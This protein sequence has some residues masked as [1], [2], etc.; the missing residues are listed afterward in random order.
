MTG[1]A[2]PALCT[3]LAFNGAHAFLQKPFDPQTLS[4]ELRGIS[5]EQLAARRIED[6]VLESGSRTAYR[7]LRSRTRE[8][9][10]QWSNDNVSQAARILGVSRR[11]VYKLID[12]DEEAEGTDRT[13]PSD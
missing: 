8:R 1:L 10:L 5:V 12:D 9:I 7:I 4:D 2:G 13:N 3:D 11:A 6:L